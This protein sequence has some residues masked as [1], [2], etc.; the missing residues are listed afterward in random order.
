MTMKTVLFICTHNS[1]RSQMAEAL[2]NHYMGD[3]YTAYSAGTEPG[4]VNIFTYIV[5]EEMG[6]EMT[7]CHSKHIREFLDRGVDF[8]HV[9]TVCDNARENCPTFPGAKNVIHRNF[10]DP[11]EVRGNNVECR[12]AFRTSRDDIQEW[13]IATFGP[14]DIN[15]Q[16][17]KRRC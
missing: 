9:V 15:E 14:Q 11:S 2:M 10:K 17:E 7:R 16:V 6:I 8:D 5:M 13:I 4:A 12:E 1:A 3:R